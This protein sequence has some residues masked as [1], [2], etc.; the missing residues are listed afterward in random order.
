MPYRR[1]DEGYAKI[2]IEELGLQG[3]VLW[4]VDG[5]LAVVDND[6]IERAEAIFEPIL[7]EKPFGVGLIF[8]HAL[9]RL[10][11]ALTKRD[12]WVRHCWSSFKWF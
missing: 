12:D 10:A 6:G 5:F 3:I 11:L 8:E 4:G 2:E 9:D 7:G 1:F